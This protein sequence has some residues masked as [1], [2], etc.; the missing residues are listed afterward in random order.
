ME[1][2]DCGGK[3]W[4]DYLRTAIDYVHMN[5]GRDGMVDGS[6]KSVLDYEWSSLA[7]AYALSPGKRPKR[8][9]KTRW[10]E[11]LRVILFAD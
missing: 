4:R 3:V 10:N 9:L 5:P 6:E 7:Q 8:L 11:K 1:N 2:A